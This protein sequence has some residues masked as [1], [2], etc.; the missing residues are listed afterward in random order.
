M[1]ISLS[2][3]V[4]VNVI[5]TLSR[6]AALYLAEPVEVSTSQLHVLSSPT[7][8]FS[9]VILQAFVHSDEAD[10]GR[11]QVRLLREGPVDQG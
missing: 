1:G 9:S 6:S 5:Y 8:F 10:P 4:S 7:P 2:P 3:L 11:F